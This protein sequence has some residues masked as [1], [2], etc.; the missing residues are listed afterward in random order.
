MSG[1][2]RVQNGRASEHKLLSEVSEVRKIG[3]RRKDTDLAVQLTHTR[4]H[5]LLQSL[6]LGYNAKKKRNIC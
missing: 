2:D 1:G 3:Q 6:T 5:L 4:L